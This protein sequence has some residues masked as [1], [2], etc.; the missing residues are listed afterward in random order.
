MGIDLRP[1]SDLANGVHT[2]DGRPTSDLSMDGVFLA[3]HDVIL[4]LH[5]IVSTLWPKQSLSIAFTKL[6]CSDVF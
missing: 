5:S 2:G 1:E 6:A 3:D 4:S